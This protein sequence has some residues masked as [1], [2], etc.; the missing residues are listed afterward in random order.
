MEKNSVSLQGLVFLLSLS[1]SIF[2]WM[3]GDVI[4][5]VIGTLISAATLVWVIWQTS[6]IQKP[7]AKII[8]E[9]LEYR[10]DQTQG[11]F[12]LKSKNIIQLDI[13]KIDAINQRKKALGNFTIH[14]QLP[15]IPGGS[16]SEITFDF[17]LT[18]ETKKF[19]IRVYLLDVK[20]PLISEWI[21]IIP[22]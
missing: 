12:I 14:H 5:S 3:S 6:S 21:K 8:L 19:K 13:T 10:R 4:L 16:S 1:V 2:C 18:N 9:A 15:H 11:K 17:P 7:K 22:A 20:K